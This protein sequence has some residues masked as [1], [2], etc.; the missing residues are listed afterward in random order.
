[1]VDHVGQASNRCSNHRFPK[2]VRNR[3][4]AALGGFNIW[5]YNY[6]GPPEQLGALLIGNVLVVNDESIRMYNHA[7]IAIKVFTPTG[8]Y[9]F[10]LGHSGGYQGFRTD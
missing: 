3:N 10:R 2:V 6:T 4:D 1:M 5:Q 7:A 9:D 8:N